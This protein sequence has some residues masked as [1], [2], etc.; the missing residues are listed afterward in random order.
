MSKMEMTYK[1]QMKARSASSRS[2]ALISSPPLSTYKQDIKDKRIK[3]RSASSRSSAQ[4]ST[5]PLKI[6]ASNDF[7]FKLIKKARSRSTRSS[8]LK[9]KR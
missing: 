5:P 9:R 8:A 2:S 4:T 7:V 3:A 6:H 1:K